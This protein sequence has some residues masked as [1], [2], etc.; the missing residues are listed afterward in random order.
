MRRCAPVVAAVLVAAQARAEPTATEEHRALMISAQVLRKEHKLVR[1]R[2][3]FE[4]CATTACADASSECA[5]IRAFCEKTLA[6]V[7]DE[8]PTASLRV[9]DDRGRIVP[10]DHVNVDTTL[11][12]VRKP[13]TLDPGHH[14]AK[15]SYAGRTGGV[16]FELAPRQRDAP[17]IVRIDLRETVSRRPVPAGVFA[18]GATSI[19]SG[20]AAL[21]TS[22]FTNVSYAS[23]SSCKPT[24][25]PGERGLLQATGGIA[26]VAS[27]LAL[28]ALV[29]GVVWYFARPTVSVVRWVR[30]TTVVEER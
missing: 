21:G 14:E 10:I 5:A 12:D 7:I 11:V 25:D 16:S 22:I 6:E 20:L 3:M 15:V 1:A 27:I 24:C 18:L 17:V 9:E 23:L 4:S 30:P 13:V 8:L 19:V 2:D 29:A 26:D 28:S